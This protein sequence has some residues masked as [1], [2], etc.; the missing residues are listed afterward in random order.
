MARVLTPG[1]VLFVANLNSFSTARAQ[2]GAARPAGETG[3]RID[4]YLE[5]RASWQA[6]RGIRILNWHRPL[7]AYMGA[8]LGAGFITILPL[9]LSQAPAAVGFPLS[10]RKVPAPE[11]ARRLEEAAQLLGLTALLE[12]KP[13]QLSGGQQQMLAMSRALMGKQSFKALSD[14]E[15]VSLAQAVLEGTKYV[16]AYPSDE[17]A[18]N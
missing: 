18:P 6:W 3:I 17:K 13:S 9:L 12:R 4:R 10:V 8:F 16:V 11:A 15:K 7:S 2:L 1:G 14:E 5:P